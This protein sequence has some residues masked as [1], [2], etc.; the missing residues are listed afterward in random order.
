[1]AKRRKRRKKKRPGFAKVKAKAPLFSE[2]MWS[3][4]AKEMVAHGISKEE[5]EMKDVS[6]HFN[7][8][9][10][11]TIQ[12]RARDQRIMDAMIAAFGVDYF[13]VK[14][15]VDL[16]LVDKDGKKLS[17]DDLPPMRDF[18]PGEFAV[19]S[20]LMVC[21]KLLEGARD[22]GATRDL[23]GNMRGSDDAMRMARI[24]WAAARNAR[25]FEFRADMHRTLLNEEAARISRG[26]VALGITPEEMEDGQQRYFE[27]EVSKHPFP[28]KV[29]FTHCFYGFDNDVPLYYDMWESR[30]GADPNAID[31]ASVLGYL[32][33]P[34]RIWEMV[35]VY[36]KA[37]H[38]EFLVPNVVWADNEWK[39]AHSL[40]PFVVTALNE[41]ILTHQTYVQS[42]RP[43]M[44]A[45]MNFK[46]VRKSNRKDSKGWLPQPY[47]VVP[48][49]DK[50]IEERQ[51]ADESGLGRRLSY[52]HDRE[53]HERMY[54]RRGPLPLSSKDAAKLEK[55]GYTIHTTTR[56][57]AEMLEGMVRRGHKPKGRDEWLAVKVRWIENTVIGDPNLPYVPA[58][59]VPAE[60]LG[61]AS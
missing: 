58:V 1:M 56:P 59:R 33:A 10:D 19:E 22:K 26:A 30:I 53:G 37:G 39:S 57:S 18:K 20:Y 43:G 42:H 14:P 25:V 7:R 11:G 47:Y 41:H 4:F 48:V 15:D 32:L 34:D 38:D 2:K 50:V 13:Q 9:S 21:K 27:R 35:Y 52:R 31:A 12:V 54:L 46:K 45:R 49:R 17:F 5:F 61:K 44:R 28:S 29:P 8:A 36:L 6:W 3:K 60:D 55:Y 24:A 51:R 40:N 16:N 23:Q